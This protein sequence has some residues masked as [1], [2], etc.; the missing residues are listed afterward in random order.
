MADTLDGMGDIIEGLFQAV[1]EEI[2]A[3]SYQ[4]NTVEMSKAE[5]FFLN[6][7]LEMMSNHRKKWRQKLHELAHPTDN[8]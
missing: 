1:D 2:R 7:R 5:L 4:I 3:L 6:H 8:S